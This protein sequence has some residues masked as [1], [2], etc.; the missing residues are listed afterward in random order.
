MSRDKFPSIFSPQMATIVFIILQIF[1]A[2]RAVL[3]SGEYSRIFPSFRSC[4][5]FRPI[6]R[7]QKDF[8]DY[9]SHYTMFYKNSERMRNFL[10][11]FTFIVVLVFY[12]LGAFLIKQLFHSRLLD[13]MIIANS[14]LRATSFD[15]STPVPPVNGGDAPWPFFHFRSRNF[16]FCAC[17]NKIVVKPRR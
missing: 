1:F 11:L 7:E 12:I 4:D 5:A 9:K 3:K 14:V 6:A 16:D 17:P 2:T 13:E 15:L 8:M 10:G